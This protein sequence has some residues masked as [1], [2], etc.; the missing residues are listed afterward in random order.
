VEG[1]G[2]SGGLK[3]MSFRGEKDNEVKGP[4]CDV[5]AK[6]LDAFC[7]CPGNWS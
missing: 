5:P 6:N 1:N 7:L 4:F 2:D 3:L